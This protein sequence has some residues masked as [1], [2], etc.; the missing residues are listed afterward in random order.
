MFPSKA[1]WDVVS[2]PFKRSQHGLFQ[3]KMKQYGNNV[4]FSKHK[5]RRTWLPNVQQKRVPSEILGQAVR[6]KITT[7]ALRTIKKKGGLDNYLKKTSPELLGYAGMK[8]RQNVRSQELEKKGK[9]EKTFNLTAYPE[10]KAVTLGS[11]PSL[12]TAR[13][14]RAMASKQLGKKD[15]ELATVEETIEYLEKF[16]ISTRKL[17]LGAPH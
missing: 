1:L 3:G 13:L 5:T 11:P 8:L 7:R 2:Q 14:A 9:K 6:L 16:R 10:P 4:P 15:G 12:L 17:P